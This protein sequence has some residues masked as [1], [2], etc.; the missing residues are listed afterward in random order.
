MLSNGLDPQAGSTV[1]VLLVSPQQ[2]TC[3][4]CE[5]H[6]V[7][8]GRCPKCGRERTPALPAVASKHHRL[9]VTAAAGAAFLGAIACS[10]LVWRMIWLAEYWTTEPYSVARTGVTVHQLIAGTLLLACLILTLGFGSI[11]VLLVVRRNAAKRIDGSHPCENC[12][13][14]LR[15]ATSSTCPE[16]GNVGRRRTP[17]TST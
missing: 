17:A 12:G 1:S 16:C 4:V 7:D 2:P 14:S 10:A 6:L 13:Y 3:P 8:S 9:Y 11:A 15:A 5:H